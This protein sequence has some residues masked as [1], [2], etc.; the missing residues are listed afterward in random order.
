MADDKKDELVVVGPAGEEEEIHDSLETGETG[1]ETEDSTDRDA[2]ER[3][4]HSDDSDDPDR[5]AIRERRRNE[6]QR[7]KENRQRE[8]VELNFLRQRNEAVERE[9]S[10]IRARQ[11]QGET[12]GI[13]QRIGTLDDQIRQAEEVHALAVTKGDG[14]AASEALRLRDEFRDGRQQLVG[15]KNQKAHEV[16][17]RQQQPNQ[18]DPAIVAR[19]NE[20]MSD[21]SW[22]DPQLRDE[23]SAIARMVEDRLYNEGRL[24]PTSDEYWEEY[25]KRLK[26]RL[27][28]RFKSVNQNGRDEE[29]EDGDEPDT[30]RRS[31]GPKITTGGRERPLRKNE[32]Y[33]DADRKAAMIEAGVWDDE[34]LRARY[35]KR[36]QQYDKE[37]GRS[38]H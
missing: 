8:R 2:D 26:K 13:D 12:L 25:N 20:W 30:R 18:P 14:A 33:I 15:L 4:S 28:E 9:L 17:T 7:K 10:Q 16:R 38:R 37:H 23:D 29:D 24:D 19:A 6:K 31:T 21:N 36:Y 11:D 32:V 1:Q 27:P 34:K 35:L 5:E 22:F 3:V